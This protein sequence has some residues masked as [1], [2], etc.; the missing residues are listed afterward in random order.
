MAN[1]ALTAAQIGLVDPSKA[2]VKDYLAGS[3][4]TK[5]QVVAMN[6]DGTV[7]PADGSAGGA[8]LFEQVVGIALQAAAA[9]YVVPVCEDGEL[10]GFTVAS[11]SCGA[12][13]YLSDTTG[14]MEDATGTKT[15]ILGR[16]TALTDKSATKVVRI[17]IIR[18]QA[19]P[20]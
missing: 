9:G 16:W 5:G 12:L 11:N 6:T 17:Q 10:Y 1:I 15:F 8:Y 13:L 18:S 3:T 14:A 4:I 7:A 20:T 2:K 19:V